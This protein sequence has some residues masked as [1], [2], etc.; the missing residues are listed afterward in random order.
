MT[1]L[2]V[3]SVL[4]VV[5]LIAGLAFYL[6]WVGTLL[7]RVATNLEECSESVR[8]I[9]SDA[10]A[11]QPGLEH[12]NRSGGTVAGALPLLY[13]F[14]ENIVGSVTP[15]PPRPSVAVPA[16]GRRRSRLAEAVGY[17]PSG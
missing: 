13:G 10:E 14:A 12:I 1:L 8:R 3:L 2:I 4:A 5:A 16:S 7:T 15:A 11:I 17:R 9:D 6:F